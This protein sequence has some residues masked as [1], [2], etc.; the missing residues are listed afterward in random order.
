MEMNLFPNFVSTK[1]AAEYV[2]DHFQWALRDPST[3]SPRLLPSDYHGLCPR[4]ELGVATRYA[5]DY[6]TPE[7]VQ[8]IFYTMGPVEAWLGDNDRRLRRAQ[9]S[10]PANP[11][12]NPVLA[13]D[14]SRGRT[15]SFPTLWDSAQAAEYGQPLLVREGIIKPSSELAPLRFT[16]YC[17]KFDHVM[18][19]QFA[20]A[21]HIS[22]MVQAIF[23]AMV[24]NDTVE[25]RLIRREIG[26]ILMLDLHELRWDII[27]A[28]LLSIDDK[29]KDAQVP[30]LVETVSNPWPCPSVTS[31]LRDASPCPA[32]RSSIK[33]V[34]PPYEGS[35][36]N[37]NS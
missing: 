26:E 24:I 35:V 30:C 7:M 20:H 27:E 23:Y 31:R 11:L 29:L 4:F 22:E 8:I 14:P 25:L 5:H 16:A 28:W 10:H 21:A 12:A 2:R 34:R 9:A 1:Q 13:G 15:T 36:C 37:H 6:N 3:P 18:A 32:T 33:I 17:P 19:M